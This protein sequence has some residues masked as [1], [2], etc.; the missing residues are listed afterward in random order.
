MATRSTITVYDNKMYT[1]IY[2]HFDGY[3]SGVGA[4]LNSHYNTLDKAKELVGLGNISVLGENLNPPAN[5]HHSFEN[6]VKGVTVAYH[7]DRGEAW[8]DNKPDVF[9]NIGQLSAQ[10]YNYLFKDDKWQ[11]I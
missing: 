11:L 3:P 6:Q 4:I 7:R 10:D 1:S 9:A 5:V 8:E 2:C